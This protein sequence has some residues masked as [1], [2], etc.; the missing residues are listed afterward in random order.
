MPKPY[1]V[2]LRERAVRALT[3]KTKQEVAA[4]YAI[5]LRTVHY[6]EARQKATGNL[7]PDPWGGGRPPKITAAQQAE[8]EAEIERKPDITLVELQIALALPISVAAIC[9]RLID[10]GFNLKKRR[11]LRASVTAPTSKNGEKSL[12][13][14]P[15]ASR[16]KS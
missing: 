16:R 12:K 4:E 11:S 5:S 3:T 10:A 9:M 14:K 6:W 15:K 2:D 1:S 13:K 8:M 7:A